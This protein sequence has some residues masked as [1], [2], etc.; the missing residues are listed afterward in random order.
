M[1]LD[2]SKAYDPVEWPFL[3]SMMLKM[4]FHEIWVNTLMRCVTSL[5]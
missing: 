2:M 5:I 3:G 1:K 4:G